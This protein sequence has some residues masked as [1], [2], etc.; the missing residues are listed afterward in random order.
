M[1]FRSRFNFPEGLPR[2]NYDSFYNA[3]LSVYQVLTIQSW[4]NLLYSSLKAQYAIFVVPFYVSW[5]LIGSYTTFNLFLAV[6]LNTF[7]EADDENQKNDESSVI[8]LIKLGR[9]FIYE[10]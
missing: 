1:L 2:Q 6:M 8:F 9:R 5:I 4:E 7:T 3:F 10:T